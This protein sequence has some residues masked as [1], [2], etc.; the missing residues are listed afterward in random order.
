[1][2]KTA[3]LTLAALLMMI[4]F[5]VYADEGEPVCSWYQGNDMMQQSMDHNYMFDGVN[6]TEHQ[7]QQMRDLMQTTRHGF[8]GVKLHDIEAMHRLVTAEQFDE[9]AVKTLAEKMA[10]ESVIRQVEMARI[11]NM[12]FNLLTSDQK[13]QLNARYHQKIAGWQQQIAYMQ[14]SSAQK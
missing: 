6:L 14:N 4:S 13:A 2:H 10:Q 1:M 3:T 5:G 11:R 9:I 8:A 12:V 7:R